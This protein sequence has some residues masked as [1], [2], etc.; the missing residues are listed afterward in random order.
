MEKFTAYTR[1]DLIIKTVEDVT[2]QTINGQVGDVIFVEYYKVTP[3]TAFSADSLVAK[4]V[5]DV[6]DKYQF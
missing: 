3:C 4:T 2:E 6:S 1:N 5:E